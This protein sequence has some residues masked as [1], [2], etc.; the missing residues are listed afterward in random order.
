M[1][2]LIFILYGIIILSWE[3]VVLWCVGMFF[4]SC[5]WWSIVGLLEARIKRILTGLLLL[6]GFTLFAAGGIWWAISSPGNSF[7]DNQMIAILLFY[8]GGA[9]LYYTILALVALYW[10]EILYAPFAR[11]Y[12]QITGRTL[13]APPGPP[14]P[15]TQPVVSASPTPPAPVAPPAPAP[16]APAPQPFVICPW[17]GHTNP[18]NLIYCGNGACLAPLRSGNRFC[19]RCGVQFQVNARFCTACG[20][21]A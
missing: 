14:P 2:N 6:T 20:S 15:A 5:Y 18:A 19:I 7:S 12:G 13:P 10:A 16:G 11:L 8:A 21:S 9:I 17:C 4:M 3:P 1:L